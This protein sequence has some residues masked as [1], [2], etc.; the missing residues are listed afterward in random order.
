MTNYKIAIDLRIKCSVRVSFRTVIPGRHVTLNNAISGQADTILWPGYEWL[1]NRGTEVT[2][3]MSIDS[4]EVMTLFIS[5]C[6]CR[7]EVN[8]IYLVSRSS[9][10]VQKTCY[11]KTTMN[12]PYGFLFIIS[13]LLGATATNI[14]NKGK[15]IETSTILN[16]WLTPTYSLTL[17]LSYR[18]HRGT[19]WLLV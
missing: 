5:S 9:S 4:G 6:F 17:T 13:T 10:A 16:S 8:A 2:R 15:Y 19:P 7:R 1:G 11:H 3:N 18:L 12:A 14:Q